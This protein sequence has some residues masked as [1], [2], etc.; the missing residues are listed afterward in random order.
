LLVNRGGHFPRGRLLDEANMAR[1]GTLVGKMP[2]S[3]IYLIEAA[4]PIDQSYRTAAFDG[5]TIHI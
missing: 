3:F 4:T 2:E 5:S 1:H